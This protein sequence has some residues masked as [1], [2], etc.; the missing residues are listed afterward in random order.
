MTIC[1]L[2]SVRLIWFS[3]TRARFRMAGTFSILRIAGQ[4]ISLRPSRRSNCLEPIA[5]GRFLK[6]QA[7]CGWR[8]P[9][10]IQQRRN[11]AT[12]RLRVNSPILIHNSTL[13]RLRFRSALRPTYASSDIPCDCEMN[14]IPNRRQWPEG[15]ETGTFYFTAT[16]VSLG[17]RRAVDLGVESIQ[18][19]SEPLVAISICRRSCK[20]AIAAKRFAITRPKICRPVLRIPPLTL[21]LYRRGM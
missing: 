12:L 9:A 13:V 17:N 8:V 7:S 4:S 10:R 6:R 14:E 18:Q 5:S 11:S 20:L 1:Q 21:L 19:R 15:A 3:D 2:S 16:A